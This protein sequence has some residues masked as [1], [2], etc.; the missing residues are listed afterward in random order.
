M[1][2]QKLMSPRERVLR[3]Y[4]TRGSIKLNRK[5]NQKAYF[6]GYPTLKLSGRNCNQII[7]VLEPCFYHLAYPYYDYNYSTDAL[8]RAT[9]KCELGAFYC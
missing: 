1:L 9:D 3:F 4:Q 7:V 5:T 2:C 8:K 6:L